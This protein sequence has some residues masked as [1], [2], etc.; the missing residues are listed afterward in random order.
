MTRIE[1]NTWKLIAEDETHPWYSLAVQALTKLSN[2]RKAVKL[3]NKML[4]P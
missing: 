4:K 1:L 3:I 2:K